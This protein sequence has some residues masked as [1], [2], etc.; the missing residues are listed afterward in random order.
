MR[1]AVLTRDF[2]PPM[3]YS[4]WVKGRSVSWDPKSLSDPV[5]RLVLSLCAKSK[6][7]IRRFQLLYHEGGQSDTKISSKR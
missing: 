7:F 6:W 1:R 3:C 2:W 4:V 5:E